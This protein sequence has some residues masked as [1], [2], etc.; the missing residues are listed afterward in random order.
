MLRSLVGSE[1]C[2]RDRNQ[3]PPPPATRLLLRE[4]GPL[5]RQNLLEPL[6][7]CR[8]GCKIEQ[9]L[10]LPRRFSEIDVLLAMHLHVDPPLELGPPLRQ[11]LL[12]PLLPRR[13]LGGQCTHLRQRLLLLL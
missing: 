13:N 10:L 8:H 1:M 5:A 3:P 12:E 6:H 4:L 2:I 9:A 11:F 7:I